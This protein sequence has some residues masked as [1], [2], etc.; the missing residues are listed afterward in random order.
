M[1]LTR[2]G[3]E[4]AARAGPA[5]AGGSLSGQRPHPSGPAAVVRGG[6]PPP[7]GA[8]LVPGH[9]RRRARV[10]G[11]GHRISPP[12]IHARPHRRAWRAGLSRV[13]Q[14][15]QRPLLRPIRLRGD[16][17]AP[18]QGR[19]PDPVAHVAGAAGTGVLRS[20]LRS[21]SRGSGVDVDTLGSVLRHGHHRLEQLVERTRRRRRETAAAL[22]HPDTATGQPLDG[23]RV[24]L[25]TEER[26]DGG[27]RQDG[28]TVS[29]EGQRGDEAESVDLGGR[30][31]GDAEGSG[32]RLELVA[33]GRPRQGQEQFHVGEVLEGQRMVGIGTGM[34]LGHHQHQV[35][36][37]QLTGH[38]VATADREM[39]HG[40]VE[41]AAGQ[42]GLQ[43]GGVALDD[44]QAELGVALAGHIHEPWHQPSSRRPD[45]PHPDRAGHLV[46]AGGHVGDQGVELREDPAGPGH[47]HGAL[48][49]ETAVGPVDEGAPNSRSR[50]ATWAEMLD[51]TVLRCSAAAEKVP[52]SLMAVNA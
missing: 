23:D 13:I 19:A 49:G 9:A 48:L 12:A 1:G 8:A 41:L 47:H 4:R 18:A 51:C 27:R 42:L 22:G 3:Q 17:G 5:V 52:W 45:H 29:L 6:R 50:R 25:I 24:E 32:H 21:V 16:R 31:E 30:E 26:G 14:G 46:L 28:R 44:D 15:A 7:L 40:Q 39:E 20:A 38:Q 37:E 2:R 11:Q 34:A 33:E 36:L 35:L 10:A 43:P